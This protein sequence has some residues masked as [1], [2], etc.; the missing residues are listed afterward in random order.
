MALYYL[1]HEIRRCKMQRRF[2]GVN[3]KGTFMGKTIL[4]L[5]LFL[6]VFCGL[7]GICHPGHLIS[8]PGIP[9]RPAENAV[10]NLHLPEYSALPASAAHAFRQQHPG[11]SLRRDADGTSPVYAALADLTVEPV[12][13]AI[14]GRKCEWTSDREIIY[15][16]RRTLPARAGPRI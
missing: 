1:D 16:A 9:I 13:I 14:S 15:R 4:P 11:K 7:H 3:T 12:L 5:L 2:S 6:T 10:E 8:G